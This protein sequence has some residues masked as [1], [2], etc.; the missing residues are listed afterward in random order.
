M[1]VLIKDMEMPETCGECR[2]S[3][4]GWC[5]A[6]AS[7]DDQ[8][9]YIKPYEKTKWCPLCLVPPHGR[10]IDADIM[11]KKYEPDMNRRIY[12]G[13]FIFDLEH[14]PTVIEAESYSE[15]ELQRDY[16]ASV[17]YAQHCGRYE[18]TYD[19]ETGAM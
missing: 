9:G 5:Y 10:L 13:N 14:A 4:D 7:N 1:S 18:L 16:E 8:P 15:R 17:E 11:I 6:I 2:F 12:G 3:V 19:P